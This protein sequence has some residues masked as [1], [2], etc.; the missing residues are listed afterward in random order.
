M[1]VDL[2]FDATVDVAGSEGKVEF[3]VGGSSRWSQVVSCT[4]K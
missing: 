3:G 1:S 2:S 4:Q